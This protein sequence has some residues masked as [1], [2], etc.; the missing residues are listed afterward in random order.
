MAST[1][2]RIDTVTSS[3]ARR[4]ITYTIGQNETIKALGPLC[5]DI[6]DPLRRQYGVIASHALV[7]H[8][9]LAPT[10]QNIPNDED[11]YATAKNV[12]ILSSREPPLERRHSLAHEIAHFWWAKDRP[13]TADE[14]SSQSLAEY[15]ALR[16]LSAGKGEVWRNKTVERFESHMAGFSKDLSDISGFS[17]DRRR[18]LSNFGPS[19]LFRF[20]DRIGPRAMTRI[21]KTPAHR[22][23]HSLGAWFEVVDAETRKK[24]RQWI[25]EAP[26]GEKA[27]CGFK[28]EMA[29][30]VSVRHAVA[31]DERE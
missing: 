9:F 31:N 24:D 25:E 27:L 20:E 18:I 2:W 7:G 23:V 14:L 5:I 16:L 26:L 21:L 19:K 22:N 1:Q 8:I 13:G 17:P 30:R 29:E 12:T 3:D 15:A 4:L 6:Y 10:D 28:S 11:S